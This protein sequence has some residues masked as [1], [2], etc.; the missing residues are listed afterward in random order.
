MESG[1]KACVFIDN[2]IQLLGNIYKYFKYSIQVVHAKIINNIYLKN[3]KSEFI[4]FKLIRNIN[5]VFVSIDSL[6]FSQSYKN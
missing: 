5:R 4:V 1:V 2:D 3:H 6:T